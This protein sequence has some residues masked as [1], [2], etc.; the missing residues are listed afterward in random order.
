MFVCF[1]WVWKKQS[2][3]GFGLSGRCSRGMFVVS[4]SR[5]WG[6][7][8]HGR[9]QDLHLGMFHRWR[10]VLHFMSGLIFR[11]VITR[12]LTRVFAHYRG[13]KL[14]NRL[15]WQSSTT[16]WFSSRR[17]SS[18]SW[19]VSEICLHEKLPEWRR[20]PIQSWADD[21]DG[22]NEQLLQGLRHGAMW[23]ETNIQST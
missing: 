7:T 5:R 2:K 12:Q 22:R 4:S 20:L 23:Y 10:S 16:K 17:V 1:R 14:S 19:S 9:M 6:R 3:W 18:G 11:K 15:N 13:T 8:S 21:K